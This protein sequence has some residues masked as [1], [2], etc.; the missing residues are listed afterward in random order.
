MNFWCDETL[1]LL[2]AQI[3]FERNVDALFLDLIGNYNSELL[4]LWIIF[5]GAEEWRS[6]L[7]K[8]RRF[9]LG[10]FQISKKLFEWNMPKNT[11]DEVKVISSTLCTSRYS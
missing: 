1:L 3:E 6:N 11:S 9:S 7:Q 10:D 8:S 4:K 5:K 2:I